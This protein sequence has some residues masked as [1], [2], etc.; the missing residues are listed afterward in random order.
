MHAA[1]WV[2]IALIAFAVMGAA[3]AGAERSVETV[4]VDKVWSGHPVGFALLTRG[5]RQFV[6][7]YD[8]ERRM[9][10]AARRLGESAWQKAVLPE[11]LGWDSHNYVT[12]AVDDAGYILSLIH[13]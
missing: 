7:Y 13:I 4:E 1:S 5:D 11:T 3:S 6:A 2:R 10:V 12:M 9:T 8:A